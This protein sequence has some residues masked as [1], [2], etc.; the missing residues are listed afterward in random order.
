MEDMKDKR[1]KQERYLVVYRN[2]FCAFVEAVDP[3][4]AITKFINGEVASPYQ[5]MSGLWGDLCEA[6]PADDDEGGISE[7]KVNMKRYR[8]VIYYRPL[9]LTRGGVAGFTGYAKKEEFFEYA[10]HAYDRVQAVTTEGLWVE[11]GGGRAWVK[12]EWAAVFDTQPSE[13]R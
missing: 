4:E 5:P 7:D 8:V 9:K 2:E 13:G 10:S 11:W 12:A 1:P 3:D 6:I